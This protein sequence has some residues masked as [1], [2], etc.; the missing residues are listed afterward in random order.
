MAAMSTT[1]TPL[2]RRRDHNARRFGAGQWWLLTLVLVVGWIAAVVVGNMVFRGSDKTLPN[3]VQSL[4][5]SAQSAPVN[6]P[7]PDGAL[8]LDRQPFVLEGDYQFQCGPVQ[9]ESL[10]RLR[11]QITDVTSAPKYNYCSKDFPNAAVVSLSQGGVIQDCQGYGDV[12]EGA[13]DLK[14]GQSV[15]YGSMACQ[16]ED[17]LIR[18]WSTETGVGFEI[19]SDGW[20]PYRR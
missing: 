2:P 16:S 9:D 1:P 3:E 14:A 20:R 19:D 13:V 17:N 10:L 5:F 18:C 4:D 12:G 15:N 6:Y 11:C 8:K 7:A